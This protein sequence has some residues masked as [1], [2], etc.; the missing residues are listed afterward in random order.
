MTQSPP[1]VVSYGTESSS[2]NFPLSL[3]YTLGLILLRR[4]A[5]LTRGGIRKKGGG[6][7]RRGG[8]Y[9]LIGVEFGSGTVPTPRVSAVNELL[10]SAEVI[11]MN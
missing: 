2:S 5:P 9:R 11:L 10:V 3:G 7:V 6:G 8:E 4:D 1:R